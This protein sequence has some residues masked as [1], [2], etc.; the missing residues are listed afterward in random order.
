MK[1][2]YT[3]VIIENE[4]DLMALRIK[5]ATQFGIVDIN[6]KK[7]GLS[8]ATINPPEILEFADFQIIAIG[9]GTAFILVS[10]L[11]CEVLMK[12]GLD[13]DLVMIEKYNYYIFVVTELNVICINLNNKSIFKIVNLPEIADKIEF[14]DQE[15]IVYC[16]DGTIFT[17]KI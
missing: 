3:S 16:I 17:K 9:H 10:V 11:D 1:F 5:N 8:W 12:F 6:G 2:N 4:V 13:Y 15:L 14:Q 7:I